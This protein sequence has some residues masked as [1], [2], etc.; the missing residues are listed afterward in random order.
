[1]KQAN[2]NIREIYISEFG[3][4]ITFSKALFLPPN[5]SEIK[6]NILDN[7]VIS[8]TSIIL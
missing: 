4:L 7:G 8:I 1:M 5:L 6:Y 3:L 2:A